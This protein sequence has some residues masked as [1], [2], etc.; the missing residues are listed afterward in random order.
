MHPI[1]WPPTDFIMRALAAALFVCSAC[2]PQVESDLPDAADAFLDASDGFVD[3]TDG[4]VDASEAPEDAQD[5]FVDASDGFVDA[6][7]GFVDASEAP[8]DA[9][10]GFVDASDGFVDA[11]DGFVDASDGFVD[12]AEPPEDASD[13]FVDA[14]EAPEDAADGWSPSEIPGARVYVASAG[15]ALAGPVVPLWKWRRTAATAPWHVRDGAGLVWFRDRLWLL[16]GWFNPTVPEWNDQYTTNEVWVSD[17]LGASWTL[18]LGHDPNPPSTGP[19]ARWTP[20]HTVGWLTLTVAGTPYMYVVGGD[21]LAVTGDVWRSTDGIEWELVTDA[22]PWNGRMLQMVGT[23]GADLYVMG[24]QLDLADAGTALSDVWRS[25]DGGLHWERLADGPWAAR[26]MAYNPIEHDG[27]LWLI[28]GGTYKHSGLRDFYND[29]WS[30]DGTTWTQVLADGS[31][32]WL[33]REYHNTFSYAGE[34]WVASGYGEDAVNH[35]DMWHSVDGVHWSEVPPVAF[36]PG[37]AD[38]IAV[39]PFGVFHASGNAMNGEVHLMSRSV[40]GAAVVRWSELSGAGPD[41]VPDASGEAAPIFEPHALG[42]GDAVVFEG[43]GYLRID[44]EAFDP[45]PDGRSVFWVARTATDVPPGD[46]VNA[47]MTVVG[48][49]RGAC[50][51]QAGYAG[52][53]IELVV[54]DA[55]GSWATGHVRRGEGQNDDTARL[56]GFT[57]ALDGTVT[58]YIDGVQSGASESQPYDREHVAWDSIGA[59]YSG[60]SRASVTLGMVVV[61][62]GVIDP[63]DLAKLVA[64]ARKW[65]VGE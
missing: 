57:H 58:A 48:D 4:F 17:D 45:Q 44:L 36:A 26:G 9:Q 39:A 47:A 7:D 27:K 13:G 55:S 54:T 38:G 42:S 53:Q 34:L 35:N 22:A 5:G 16:G 30:F 32:P 1:P 18:V 28:G 8:E 51:H 41:L 61:V 20:R 6:T 2:S 52:D 10:D 3:A 64:Y 11:S 49:S 25:R 46:Q 24:G 12:A 50:R 37:H 23:L 59:G 33:G 15:V 29:V 31:A 62:P 40:E 19:G 65:G 56:V 43:S 14:T 60:G 21:Y 63:A